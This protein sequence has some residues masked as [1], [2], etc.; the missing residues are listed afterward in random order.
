M[1]RHDKYIGILGKM[2][3]DIDISGPRLA[4]CL[5]YNNDIVSFGLNDFTKTHPLQAKFGKNKDAIF[6]HAEINCIKNALKLL[7]LEELSKCSMYI[8][9][10]KY[11]DSY[12]TDMITALAKPCTG[13]ERCIKTFNIRNVFYSTEKGWE[14]L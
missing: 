1:P 2:A 7:S 9:R 14:K 11:T 5:V 10:M 6:P 13:C 4:S 3:R 12:K 8:T